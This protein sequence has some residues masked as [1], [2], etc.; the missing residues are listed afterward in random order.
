M[1]RSNVVKENLTAWVFLLPSLIFLVMFTLYPILSTFISSFYKSDL[2][3]IEPIFIG[4]D[5]YANMMKDEVFRKA[6]INNIWFT[7]G[8]VPTSVLLGLLLA[9]LV[10]RTFVGKVMSRVFFFYPVVI[11]MVAVSFIWLFFYTPDYGMINSIL[12]LIG[13]QELNL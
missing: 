12:K 8:T 3:T 5:N 7:I 1:R 11:P 4:F 9:I 10:N 2:S 13:F 6:F